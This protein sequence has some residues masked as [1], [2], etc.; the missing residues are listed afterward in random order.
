VEVQSHR[1]EG[2]GLIHR[3]CRAIILVRF[4]EPKTLQ[5]ATRQIGGDARL[6]EAAA[7]QAA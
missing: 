1:A 2:P 6:A 3:S 7:C 4:P 5:C